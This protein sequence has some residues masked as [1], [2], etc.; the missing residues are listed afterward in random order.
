MSDVS[1]LRHLYSQEIV[2]VELYIST[3]NS[4]IDGTNSQKG[5]Y[6]QHMRGD[7]DSSRGE[8]VTKYTGKSSSVNTE[9]TNLLSSLKAAKGV[10]ADVQPELRR[11][12]RILD[13]YCTL[14]KTTGVQ[15]SLTAVSF[16]R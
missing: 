1:Q 13:N 12:L 9:V 16:R 4:V 10:L 14:E 2:N 15:I 11:R 8:F 5:T 6:F 3:I 7:G